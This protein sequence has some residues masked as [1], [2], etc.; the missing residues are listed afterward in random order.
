[1]K[2]RVHIKVTQPVTEYMILSGPNSA[3]LSGLV[4]GLIAQGWHPVG[5]L[6]IFP[7]FHSDVRGSG[8]N[9]VLFQ[10]MVKS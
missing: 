10:A 7:G 1:M 8:T 9:A 6:A 2:R 5:G 4:N 3:A